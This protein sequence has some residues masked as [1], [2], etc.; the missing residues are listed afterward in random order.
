MMSSGSASGGIAPGGDQGT[1]QRYK[2]D[3]WIQE[4]LKHAVPHYR[5]QKVARVANRIARGRECDL[6]DVGCGPATLQRLLT[7]N[8]RYYGIDMAIHEPAPNLR[9]AD[10]LES[11]IG[12]DGRRFGIVV[13]QGV[14]EYVGEFQDEKLAE[15]AGL[16]SQDGTFIVSYTN[17]GHRSKQLFE[18]F[19]NVRPLS[20]FRQ[21]LARHFQVDR[22][23]PA[24]HNPSGGQPARKLVKAVN[25]H[26]NRNIPLLSTRFAVE[27]LA[28]CSPRRP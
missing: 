1:A 27:Y 10:F 15:I 7:G 3:F 4:N 18:A 13:A 24:S 20:E 11:P 17:F 8:M 23:F 19:S 21:G 22:F 28:I 5:L 16:L 6:L 14:F 12:F 2:R 25:M 9:E 26:V